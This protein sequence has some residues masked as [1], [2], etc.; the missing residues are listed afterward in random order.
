VLPSSYYSVEGH[1]H[2]GMAMPLSTVEVAYQAIQQ[3][4]V[5]PYQAPS[6]TE[7]DDI[8]LEP[9]WA[10]N[11]S[12]SY[13]YIILPLDEAIIEEMTGAERPWEDMHHI[14]YFLPDTSCVE[15]GEFSSVVSRSFYRM[16]NPLARHG[17]YV[18]GNMENIS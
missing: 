8:F 7:E 9:I 3:A 13:L 4:T 10:H 11:S 6:L 18:Q 14:F 16:V 15:N 5:D 2:V 17:V 12:N 1:N